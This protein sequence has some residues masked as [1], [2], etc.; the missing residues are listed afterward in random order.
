MKDATKELIKKHIDLLE[1]ELENVNDSIAHFSGILTDRLKEKEKLE[2]QIEQL[3][4][5]LDRE[6]TE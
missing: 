5:D 6:A 1:R 3:K 2:N 4:E